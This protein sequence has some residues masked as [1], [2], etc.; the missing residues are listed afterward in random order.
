MLERPPKVQTP[1]ASRSA[2]YR[3]RLK[4]G[5]AVYRIELGGEVLDMAIRLH[6]L[7]EAEV[8]DRRAVERALG[9]MLAASART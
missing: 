5:R 9:E 8:L 1:A 7:S 2:R 6:W 4:S 3:Q